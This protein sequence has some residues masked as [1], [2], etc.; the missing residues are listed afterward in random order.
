MDR[1]YL[2]RI[3]LYLVLSVFAVC[4]IAELIFHFFTSSDNDIV[5]ETIEKTIYY[6]SIS[7]ECVVIRN[8]KS[9]Y[10]GDDVL[11][12]DHYS[13]GVK[14]SKNT[15]SFDLYSNSVDNSKTL[16][17][18]KSVNSKI[19]VLKNAVS[20]SENNSVNEIKEQLNN[21]SYQILSFESSFDIA[22]GNF[23]KYKS[24][25]LSYNNDISILKSSLYGF[26]GKNKTD[27]SVY[28]YSYSDSFPSS[29]YYS[30]IASGMN[31]YNGYYELLTKSGEE[32]TDC[33]S[34]KYVYSND[35]YCVVPV[36]KDDAKKLKIG[37][38]YSVI[39]ND[40][41]IKISL[42]K[43]V[44]NEYSDDAFLVFYGNDFLDSCYDIRCSDIVIINNSVDCYKIPCG[45][46]H[47]EKN[48]PGIFV[49]HGSVMNYLQINIIG[50]DDSY[51]Y[52]ST[53]NL[54][55]NDLLIVSGKD[56]KVGRIL[57]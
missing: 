20:L 11:Y 43:T 32:I 25:L 21:L 16:N 13:D 45:A 8:E 35:W 52:I 12:Y 23:S 18:I 14:L 56:L 15:L 33:N 22:S 3:L 53:E 17:S 51:F 2:S 42:L 57:S 30:L 36:L 26:S 49:M 28:Y 5:V 31:D 44:L 37:S 1:R 46:V 48:D 50:S 54:T 38:T 9:L 27:K 6:E 29:E 24:I 40:A 41:P 55:E 34:P 4:L 39:L 10:S 7:S 19:D 47:Y